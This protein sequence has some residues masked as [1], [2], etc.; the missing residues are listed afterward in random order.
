[1][2]APWTLID[3]GDMLTHTSDWQP[4]VHQFGGEHLLGLSVLP[5]Y[6]ANGLPIDGVKDF[7]V[8]LVVFELL[9]D[10]PF[11]EDGFSSGMVDLLFMLGGYPLVANLEHCFG[12]FIW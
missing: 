1:M 2:S 11:T 12:P 10:A 8:P 5:S 6:R 4:L 3:L 9:A 7:I